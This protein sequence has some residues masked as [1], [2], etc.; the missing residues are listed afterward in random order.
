M[1]AKNPRRRALSC[2]EWIGG[3]RGAVFRPSPVASLAPART[4][5]GIKSS[6]G[7][8]KYNDELPGDGAIAAAPSLSSA[9]RIN[10]SLLTFARLLAPALRASAPMLRSTTYGHT[11]GVIGFDTSAGFWL[12]HSVPRFPLVRVM[13]PPPH[14]RPLNPRRGQVGSNDYPDEERIYGQSF[15][16][17]SLSAAQTNAVGSL[18]LL[19]RPDVYASNMPDELQGFYTQFDAVLAKQWITTA[20]SNVT[21]LTTLGGASFTAFAK[22]AEWDSVRLAPTPAPCWPPAVTRLAHRSCTPTWWRRTLVPASWRR[23]GS[24]RPRCRPT[25]RPPGSRRP[26][27]C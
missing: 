27:R 7:F 16:C 3:E 4:L 1:R 24:D 22:N 17:I 9:P 2:P 13:R 8:L 5:D 18:L 12:V 21:T 19:N 10:H 15:L 11:K 25:A 26:T 20:A 14:W 23:R 6:T